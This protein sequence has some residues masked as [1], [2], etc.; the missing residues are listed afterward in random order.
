MG[1]TPRAQTPGIW[2]CMSFLPR[3]PLFLSG[4]GLW[5]PSSCHHLPGRPLD[6]STRCCWAFTTSATVPWSQTQRPRARLTTGLGRS[7]LPSHP[8]VFPSE[9]GQTDVAPGSS[10]AA[11]PQPLMCINAHSRLPRRGR[12]PEGGC[13]AGRRA[14]GGWP[15]P[16]SPQGP[17][18]DS[19][20]RGVKVAALGLLVQGERS[21]KA[22]LG[23]VPAAA[24]RAG[25]PRA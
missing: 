1:R 17:D 11:C 16:Q 14:W 13:P 20:S 4:D 21:A 6:G 7:G 2:G 25:K 5:P 15:W 22:G 12:C 24:Q 3:D 8:Q 23:S 10:A 18:R 9:S 19:R